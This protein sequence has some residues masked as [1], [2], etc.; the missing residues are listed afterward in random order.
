MDCGLKRREMNLQYRVYIDGIGDDLKDT[1]QKGLEFI[2]WDEYIGKES[3]VFVKPNFT[4]PSYREGVTTNPQFLKYLL[5]IIKSRA[6]RVTLGESDGGNHSFTAD[7][8]FEGHNMHEICREIGVEL[9]NLSKMPSRFVKGEI[10]GKV[11]EVLLPELLLDETDCF[12]SVPV[13]KVH[14]MTTISLSLK[15]S[16]GCTP[17][18]MRYLHHQNLPHKLALIAKLLRPKIVVVDATYALDGHGPMYGEPVKTDMVLVA[19]NTVVADAMGARIMGFSPQKIRTITMA[20]KIGLGSTK[21]DDVE[22][23]Q[24]WQRYGRQFQVRKTIVDR[25]SS[26]FFLS[27]AFAKLV[28]DSPLTSAIYKVAN[29]FK[30]KMEKE[31]ASQLGNRRK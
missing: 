23:N 16:W 10:Q 14:T 7:Q 11:V 26:L 18:T 13:L 21:L 31:L 17:D 6:G 19:D 20:E 24:N 27:D 4:F 2:H 15:N 5:E 9:V 22:T 29:L 28:L 30:N 3:R 12:I 1:L 25:V 8:A